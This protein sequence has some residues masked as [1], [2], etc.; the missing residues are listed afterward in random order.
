M[1]CNIA[2]V[3]C[4][5][6][7]RVI[8]MSKHHIVYATVHFNLEICIGRHVMTYK[9]CYQIGEYRHYHAFGNR[10]ERE[11]NTSRQIMQS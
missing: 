9:I 5:W 2:K 6:L 8:K 7:S 4:T 3:E 10:L 11:R 1:I